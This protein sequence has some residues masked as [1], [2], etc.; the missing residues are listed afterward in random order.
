MKVLR[1]LPCLALV[2]IGCFRQPPVKQLT[3]TSTRPAVLN[4]VYVFKGKGYQPELNRDAT[5]K[6]QWVEVGPSM[7]SIHGEDAR[8]GGSVIQTFAGGRVGLAN[9]SVVDLKTVTLTYGLDGG[10]GY[11]EGN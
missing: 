9:G 1:L 11:V 7:S 2:A 3:G 5:K 4:R 8:G 10:L 6:V